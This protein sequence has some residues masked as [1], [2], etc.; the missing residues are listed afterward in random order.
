[1]EN[2]EKAYFVAKET[3]LWNEL[4]EYVEVFGILDNRTSIVRAQWV[5]YYRICKRFFPE[6]RSAGTLDS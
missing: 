4:N 3:E 2:L 5:T 1:M 6:Y